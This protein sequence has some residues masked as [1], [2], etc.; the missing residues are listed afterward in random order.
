MLC[1]EA[2]KCNGK[3]YFFFFLY[4][5]DLPSKVLLPDELLQIWLLLSF[6]LGKTWFVHGLA[7][8]F[9]TRCILSPASG[10]RMPFWRKVIFF[11]L[12]AWQA[13]PERLFVA[14]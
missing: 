9:E 11:V 6:L 12:R 7:H 5:M 10:G 14:L 8:R 2:Q 1:Q 4:W 3:P 13:Q